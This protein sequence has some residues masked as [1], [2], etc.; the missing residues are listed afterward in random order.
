MFKFIDGNEKVVVASG[1]GLTVVLFPLVGCNTNE[2][3]ATFITSAVLDVI[4]SIT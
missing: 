2:L 1:A 4:V 3:V